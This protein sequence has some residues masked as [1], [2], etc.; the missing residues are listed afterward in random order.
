MPTMQIILS[1]VGGQGLMLA[2]NLL[3][4]AA[5]EFSGLQAV[6]TSVYGVE[7]RGTFTK[8][9]VLISSEEITFP[10]VLAA[11]VV[12]ALDEIAYKRYVANLAPG[13]LLIFDDNIPE[14]P[15]QAIQES[16]PISSTAKELGN[17][18][19]ANV[20]ALGILAAKTKVVS[21]EALQNALR[22]EFASR[23]NLIELNLK[24][25]ARGEELALQ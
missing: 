10:E 17:L 15:S 22:Q 9:D 20:V 19:V 2:G 21:G 11:D 5:V 13:V 7:T 3:G 8:S 24:A 4:R 23:P 14:Q 25:L 1:G 16:Y 18:A 12:V 6:M